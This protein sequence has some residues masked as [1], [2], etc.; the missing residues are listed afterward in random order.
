MENIE[1]LDGTIIEVLKKREGISTIVVTKSGLEF[2]VINIAWGCDLGDQYAHITTN[3]SPSIEGEEI[4]LFFT[5]E[6]HEIQDAL[7]RR[8]IYS[9]R[10]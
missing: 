1:P 6:I 3:I 2:H 4:E 10:P 9:N 7:D 5:S 8:V